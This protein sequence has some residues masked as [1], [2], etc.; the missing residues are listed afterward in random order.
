M[1]CVFTRPP[2]GERVSSRRRRGR[3]SPRTGE[4]YPDDAVDPARFF[5]G[6]D[7][8]RRNSRKVD[9]LCKQV[10][11]AAASVLAGDCRDECLLGACVAA[12]QP[13]PDA[14]RLMVTVVIASGLSED[15]LRDAREALGR[16]TALFRQEVARS[17]YRKRVPEIVFDVRLAQEMP[18]E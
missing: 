3:K 16:S 10:D 17:I 8:S 7:R 12:V 5:G 13:A 4:V 11:R 18:F 15:P 9:Q 14:A 1:T 6:G 2:E